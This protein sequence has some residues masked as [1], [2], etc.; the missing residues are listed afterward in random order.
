MAVFHN[1]YKLPD[2]TYFIVLV[3]IVLIN[4]QRSHLGTYRLWFSRGIQSPHLQAE[5]FDTILQG[6]E[7]KHVKHVNRWSQPSQVWKVDMDL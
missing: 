4:C 5:A 1:M 7:P 2:Q 6:R 3:T